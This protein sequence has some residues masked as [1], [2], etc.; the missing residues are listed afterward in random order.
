VVRSGRS[1]VEATREAAARIRAHWPGSALEEREGPMAEALTRLVVEVEVLYHWTAVAIAQGD[2]VSGLEYT[3]HLYRIFE[4]GLHGAAA[5]L[6]GGGR[7][8]YALPSAAVY[9]SRPD[10]DNMVQGLV[11]TI[12]VNGDGAADLRDGQ[13][14][15]SAENLLVARYR[16]HHF[17][18][19]SPEGAVERLDRGFV[20][21]RQEVVTRENLRLMLDDLAQWL[22]RH[23]QESGLYEYKYFPARD[24][25]YGEL[26][27]DPHDAFNLVRHGLAVYGLLMAAR[28]LRDRSLMESAVKGLYVLLDQTVIGPGWYESPRLFRL[29]SRY[30]EVCDD[31]NPCES[32]RR[33]LQGY[34]RLSFGVPRPAAEGDGGA[35]RQGVS[36]GPW[37]SPGG[38]SLVLPPTAMFV[39]WKD[40]AKMGASAVAVMAIAELLALRPEL[41]A[42]YRSFLEGYA[43][44]FLSMQREDGSFH[45][46][47][48]HP[49]DRRYYGKETTIYPGEILFALV[50]LYRLLGDEALQE[51]FLRG[52]AHYREWFQREVELRRDDGSYNEA[53]FNDLVSFVPWMTIAC[54]EMQSVRPRREYGTFAVESTDWLLRYQYTPEQTTDLSYLGGYY[55]VWSELPAMHGIVYTEATAAAVALAR[56]SDQGAFERLRRATLWGCRFA[57]QQVM[58]P[59]RDD[60]YL[61]G[62]RARQ[63]AAGGVRFNLHQANMR[64]D[65]AYHAMSALVRTLRVLNTDDWAPPPEA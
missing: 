63:R 27:H 38:E 29:P 26:H 13:L 33:C 58:R 48:A 52:F 19:M 6:R 3:R 55:R 2:G 20:P 44:W 59:G 15:S 56:R 50:H 14:Y 53:R 21:T 10:V 32:P 34:C 40:V 35:P 8:H 36:E 43:T 61:P 31:E 64:I 12:D 49:E 57:Y 16:T 45:H 62:D 18:E 25:F 37:P 39:R 54:A 60:H 47:L 42:R 46:Y 51:A 23:Q 17:R 9:R 4:L 24:I 22:L 41:F 11:R 30:R 7:Y 1:L 28:E 5:K 65:Y